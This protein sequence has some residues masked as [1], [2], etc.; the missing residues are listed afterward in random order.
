MKASL[1]DHIATLLGT[2]VKAANS[3][4]GGDISKAY[5]LQTPSELFF[6]KTNDNKYA[7][8]MF[9]TETIGLEAIRR[10]EIIKS[11]KVYHSGSFENTSF[12]VMEYV[13]NRRGSQDEM[14]KFGELLGEF[15]SQTTDF[16]GWD[17]DN[18]IGSLPQ[19]N[20]QHR[21]WSNF[22]VTERLIPQLKMAR[23]KGLL[24]EAHIPSETKMTTKCNDLLQDVR[25]SLLHGDLWSGNYIISTYGEPY[26]I[27]PSTYFGHSEVDISMSQLFGGFGDSFYEAYHDYVP[28]S[29]GYQERME[30]YQLY[31]L[32]VHLNLFGKTYHDSVMRLLRYFR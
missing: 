8:H 24:S 15:H 17:H 32:L 2:T 7:G 11:P 6:V 5:L 29:D 22:Y 1:L 25:P 12:I 27:D 10:G 13:D 31:Y 18:Y 9:E 26:L 28:Q 20:S 21:V 3:I 14:R 16:F 23:D 4:S 19:S 30:V